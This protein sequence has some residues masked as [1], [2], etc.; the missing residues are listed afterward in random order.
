MR[1]A[2]NL[3]TTEKT[4][5]ALP[6]IMRKIGKRKLQPGI[7][8][9]TIASNE[10]NLLDVFHSIYYLQPMFANMNPDIVGIAENEDA[11]KDLVTKI[12]EDVWKQR[13]DFDVRAYFH[14]QE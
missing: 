4:K 11:A 10:Q 6:K 13:G 5:K 7:W 3:Y 9:I 12:T 8:L 2:V 1:W 14:F